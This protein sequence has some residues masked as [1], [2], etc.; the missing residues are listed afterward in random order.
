M[1]SQQVIQDLHVGYKNNKAFT[2]QG[3]NSHQMSNK[4]VMHHP[5]YFQPQSYTMKKRN[6]ESITKNVNLVVGTIDTCG[7]LSTF[8]GPYMPRNIASSGMNE[9]VW[10]VKVGSHQ[11]H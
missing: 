9:G 11:Q 7:E 1:S 3:A 10:W 5:Q 2:L 8:S 4:K 6:H